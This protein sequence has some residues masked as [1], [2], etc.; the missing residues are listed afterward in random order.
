MLAK[1]HF[2]ARWSGEAFT[3]YFNTEFIGHAQSPDSP[4]FQSFF[5]SPMAGW[6]QPFRKL[7]LYVL[8]QFNRE[9][10]LQK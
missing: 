10:Y 5:S 1:A 2:M 6:M 4:L 9:R 3:E 8:S 7:Q